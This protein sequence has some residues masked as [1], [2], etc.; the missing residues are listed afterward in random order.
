MALCF[1]CKKPVFPFPTCP[2]H[3]QDWL[4]LMEKEAALIRKELEN[5]EAKLAVKYFLSMPCREALT[6]RWRAGELD[7]EPLIEKWRHLRVELLCISPSD[8]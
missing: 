5:V 2:E 8:A 3:A 4:N 1:K 7:S 6:E